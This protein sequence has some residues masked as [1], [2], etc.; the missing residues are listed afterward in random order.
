MLIPVQGNCGSMSTAS[1]APSSKSRISI[2]IG[3]GP[4]KTRISGPVKLQFGVM[5]FWSGNVVLRGK[6]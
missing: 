4:P 3:I 1:S 6:V 5:F 2:R